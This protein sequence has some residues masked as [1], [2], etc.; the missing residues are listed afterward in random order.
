M[1]IQTG[2]TARLVSV[3]LALRAS[4]GGLTWARRL[5]GIVDRSFFVV[6]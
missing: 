4:D 2:A 1:P 6:S 5:D 3:A